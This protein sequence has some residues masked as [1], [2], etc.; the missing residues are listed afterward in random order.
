M[1]NLVAILCCA[2]TLTFVGLGATNAAPAKAGAAAGE[3]THTMKGCEE[4]C[5]RCQ[6]MCETTLAYCRKKGGNYTT[7]K[8]LTMLEDCIAACKISADY[9]SRSSPNHALS[10]NLCAE[11]CKQCIAQCE[12]F[13]GDKQMQACA[14][15]CKK[16]AKSCSDMAAHH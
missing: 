7:G 9:L 2:A 13:K 16:C 10:C 14:E 5:Y 8:N 3:T 6:K 11:V 1:K 4:V 12:T 15:E